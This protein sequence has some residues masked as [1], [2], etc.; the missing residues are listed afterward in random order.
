MFSR[1]VQTGA[2]WLTALMTLIAGTPHLVCAC[3]NGN[4]KPF[5]F[6]LL[7]GKNSGCCDGSCCSASQV[8][9]GQDF[10]TL[11]SLSATVIKKSCCCYKAHQ[12]AASSESRS[13]AKLGKVRCQK[14]L[15]EGI[16]AVPEPAV[17]APSQ[18]LTSHLF[19]PTPEPSTGQD[20]FG[21]CDCSFA[22]QYHWPPPTD[23]V[24]VLQRFLI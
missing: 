3:P 1:T 12:E 9:D 20:G 10:D 15:V 7:S 11:P 8:G 6:A 17:K 4:A 13:D 2:I 23:L 16:T 19:V 24:T 5:Y 22:D 21:V 14:T 18:D